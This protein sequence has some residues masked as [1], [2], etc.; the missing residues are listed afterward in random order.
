VLNTGDSVYV[1]VDTNVLFVYATP[2]HHYVMKV[3][4]PSVC[5]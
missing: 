1:K 4:I 2:L 3:R 5:F